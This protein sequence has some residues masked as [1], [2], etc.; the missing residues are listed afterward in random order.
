MAAS[1]S[2]AGPPRPPQRVDGL[3][4]NSH[5]RLR[6]VWERG[7][8]LIGGWCLIPSPFAAELMGRVGFDWVC[9]DTQH[10]LIGYDSMVP[11][12]QALHA[13]GTPS[14]VRVPWNSPDQIMKALDAGAHGVIVPMVDSVADAKAAVGACR[15][16][17]DGFRSWGPI[18]AAFAHA[19]FNPAWANRDVVCVLMIETAGGAAHADEILSVP[20]VDGIY[21][22]PAD[23]ALTH[24]MRP[25]AGV[26]DP[27]HESLVLAIKAA[28]DRA[29]IVAG[30]HCTGWEAAARWRDHGFRMINVAADAALVRTGATDLLRQLAKHVQARE[31]GSS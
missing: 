9:I 5:V 1:H 21:I 18:R 11:M 15:Y 26:T 27:D 13:T 2:S 31:A 25:D 22:G 12:L 20:G 14:L 6:E 16:P 23:L 10:G 4:G 17:P 19:E 7:G 3:M 29:G 8:A 30:I 28:C 24:G